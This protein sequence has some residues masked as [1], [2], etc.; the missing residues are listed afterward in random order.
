M[1]PRRKNNMNRNASASSCSVWRSRR[2]HSTPRNFMH[3]K[4]ETSKTPAVQTEGRSAGEGLDRTARMYVSEESDRGVIPHGDLCP[5]ALA[6]RRLGYSPSNPSVLRTRPPPEEDH[7][8][9]KGLF[10]GDA[11][12]ACNFSF[13][14]S[15]SSPFFQS[16]TAMAA[17]LRA[18]VRRAI[19]GFMPFVSQ[20]W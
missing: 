17:I 2:P 14:A 6:Y 20:A 7:R 19:I 15:K 13:S 18:R 1:K 12:A 5:E 3:E 10:T 4:R 11:Q 16:I 9:W 8:R